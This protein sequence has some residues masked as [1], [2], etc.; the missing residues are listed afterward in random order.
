MITLMVQIGC[1][2]STTA[3]PAAKLEIIDCFVV[4][5]LLSPFVKTLFKY[6]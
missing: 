1:V 5:E 3:V 2:A 4:S 6:S